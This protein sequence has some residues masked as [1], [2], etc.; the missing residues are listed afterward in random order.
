LLILL[1]SSAA[2]NVVLW[3]GAGAAPDPVRSANVPAFAGFAEIAGEPR[4]A[5][6]GTS[7]VAAD[8]IA[9][10]A[11]LRSLEDDYLRA[12]RGVSDQYWSA[13]SEY[14]PAYQQALT[15]GQKHLRT[16][17]L[18]RYGAAAKDDPLFRSHFRPLDPLYWFL[19][20]DE[21]LAIQAL[22]FG[23]DAALQSA[24]RGA[25]RTAAADGV[26]R[27][28]DVATLA[29]VQKYQADLATVLDA[30]TLFEF[31]LRDSPV[32]AQLRTSGL[33]FTESE[34]RQVYALMAGLQGGP[35]EIDELIETR[36]RLR[37]VLGNRRFAALWAARDP[38][39]ADLS[40]IAERRSLPEGMALAV[41]ELMNEF[42]DRRIGLA[43]AAERDPGRAAQAALTL[44]DD[45]RMAITRLVG[46]EVAD[47]IVRGRALR[48]F[49]MFG[50]TGRPEPAFDW[51]ESQGG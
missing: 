26:M 17:L 32:A 14:Q 15:D 46:E 49:R 35:A 1:T 34:F 41:Y 48:S 22:R 27:V 9:K 13:D 51:Q 21:Q 23:R 18:G 40:E 10:L 3:F 11:Q 38:G 20:S 50:G 24:A 12:A 37:E 31:E 4:G 28:G 16:E 6:V 30:D 2:L 7:A 33:N 5:D 39:F 45:E 29:V 43:K 8:A 19:T 36:H 25:N 42:Q 47:E 44:A